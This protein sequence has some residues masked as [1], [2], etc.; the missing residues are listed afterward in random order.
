[1]VIILS[2]DCTLQKTAGWNLHQ[3]TGQPNFFVVFLSPSRPLMTILWLWKYPSFWIE[4]CTVR[5]TNNIVSQE[6]AASVLTQ[7]LYIPQDCNA[8]HFLWDWNNEI[9]PVSLGEGQSSTILGPRNARLRVAIR[10]TW[11]LNG[12]ALWCIHVVWCHSQFW[13]GPI[14][15]C[16]VLCAAV[17]VASSDCEM[18]TCLLEPYTILGSAS[19]QPRV[20]LLCMLDVEFL[21][22]NWAAKVV[23]YNSSNLELLMAWCFRTLLFWNKAPHH[24]STAPDILKEHSAFTFKS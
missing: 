6:Y 18:S 5:L 2:F 17:P 12:A 15:L 22:C 10:L 9:S 20:W 19:I 24:C 11:Y 23:K 1:M 8:L 4:C 14:P 13:S 16:K 3:E 7:W 21:S